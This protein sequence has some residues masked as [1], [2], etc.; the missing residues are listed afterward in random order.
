MFIFEGIDNLI[1][2]LNLPDWCADAVLDTIHLVPFL[3]FVFL[4][5]ELIEFFKADELNNLVRKSEKASTFIGSLLAIF[6][7]C[8]FSVI[9]STLYI[10]RFITKGTLIAVFLATSDEAIPLI[11][12]RPDK[13]HFL[14]PLI[15]VKLITAILFGYLVDFILKDDKYVFKKL[16]I[17]EP[18]GCC[19]HEITKK[20]K[21][22]LIYHPLIHT[23]H[24]SLFILFI[25]IIINLF[26]AL[27]SDNKIWHD[28]FSKISI[29]A[30]IFT[31]MF[32]LIPNCAISIALTILLFNGSISFGAAM[33]GLLSNAG[34][35]ILVLLKNKENYKDTLKIIA[36]LYVISVICGFVIQLIHI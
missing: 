17:E 23:L 7:Q 2:A 27:I 9:A 5:I 13:I 36:I 35:G 3:F 20:R 11:L 21:R 8:G 26:M 15:C 14:I 6:P 16:D 33:A 19:G 1:E 24:I 25:S 29:Y 34:L 10:K 28:L 4:I 30:P 31:A 18:S 22:D 32:G 12:A